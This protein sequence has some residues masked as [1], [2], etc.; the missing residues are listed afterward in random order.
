M[1]NKTGRILRW[2]LLLLLLAGIALFAGCGKKSGAQGQAEQAVSQGQTEQ[3]ASQSQA[4]QAASQGQ[5][6]QPASQ[7]QAEQTASQ[8]QT[9]QA[10]SQSQTGQS[11]AAAST[12]DDGRNWKP[13]SDKGN[14]PEADSADTAGG[15]DASDVGT[16][17]DSE[18][19]IGSGQGLAESDGGSGS[20]DTAADTAAL[21]EDG[22]YTTKEEVALYLHLY[23]HLPGNYITKK[24]AENIGWDSHAGN[25][26]DVA[27][28]KSI[29]GSRF[30]N[31]EG[32]LP[33]KKGRRYFECDIN[34][35]GG[36]R[37]AERIIYSDDGLVFYTGDHYKTFEQLY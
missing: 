14:G 32:L 27:P 12:V 15:A 13:L 37:G 22:S 3:A 28:G 10:A 9:E 18:T 8:G 4:G 34:Y 19:D 20:S 21:D 6:E 30:G 29:G 36:Y 5:A 11:P 7:S 23:G 2:I 16:A 26:Q 17:A 24:E 35:A 25:L 33:D 1:S 31:Y